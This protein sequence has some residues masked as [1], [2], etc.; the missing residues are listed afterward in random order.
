MRAPHDLDLSAATVR[1]L[2][3]ALAA[4]HYTVDRVDEL[5]GPVASAALARNETTPGLRATA[6]GS[7]LAT[8]ARLWQLQ[9]PVPVE[10]TERALPKLL[11]PLCAAGVLQRSVDEVRA[12]VD[13][14]PYADE[15]HDWWVMSDLVPGLDGGDRRV[16]ADHVLNVGAA[17]TTLAQLTQ[18]RP[19]GSAL[20]LGTGCGVQSLHL[21]THC[22]RTV[23]TDVN[24]RALAMARVNAGLNEVEVDL[25]EGGLFEP[26]AG[27]RFDLVTANPPFVVSPGG[28]ERL[29]YRDSGLPGDELVRRIVATVHQHLNPGGWCQM[30]A[31]WEHR[32][33]ESWQDRLAG[34]VA[35]TGC[36]A[37]V[38]QREALDP[39]RYVEMW[40]ADAGLHR[41][42]EYGRRYDAWLSWFAEQNV[43]A[44]G[45][46][47][48]NL[49]RVDRDPPVVRVEDWPYD[50]E[51]P[52]GPEV[53]SWARRTD[54]LG[55]HRD[56]LDTRLHVAPDVVQETS[57]P[58]GEQHPE[59][60]VLRQQRGMR[61]ARQVDTVEAGLVGACDGDLT[62][63]QILDALAALLDRDA[64]VLRSE[65][66]ERVRGIVADG[67][68]DP[69]D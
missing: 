28:A 12:R 26:V 4:V 56:V 43:E 65:Y 37:W 35:G 42:P 67:F 54:W 62:V 36:D 63:G 9:V 40:L 59:R 69:A 20:D 21:S 31:N 17:S 29:V 27:E 30:L 47:W 10:E 8:L 23:G 3:Y 53:A 41:S 52:L 16:A 57:G 49:R 61:R 66:A 32:A 5:L 45:F 48:L 22:A 50:V 6:D 60:I 1:R 15:G 38:V 68:V 2:R 39:A 33:G 25:R 34:W 13:V 11:D 64:A 51:Q 19:F 18:R 58:P 7:P 46:G 24:A 14:R 55:R 44:I